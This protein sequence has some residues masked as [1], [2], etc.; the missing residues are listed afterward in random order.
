MSEKKCSPF[1]EKTFGELDTL[2]VQL[3]SKSTFSRE[4]LKA[5]ENR[6][7]KQECQSQFSTQAE[8]KVSNPT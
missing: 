4:A 2:V 3:E 5:F 6:L 8:Q 7:N 1:E